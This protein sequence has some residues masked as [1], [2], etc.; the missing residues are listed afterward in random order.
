MALRKSVTLG[1]VTNG[2]ALL[3]TPTDLQRLQSLGAEMVRLEF[4]L[5]GHQQ[6]DSAI[7]AL[8]G[9]VLK[10]LSGAGIGVLGLVCNDAV[11]GPHNQQADWNKNATEQGGSDGTNSFQTAYAKACTT[12]AQS[13]DTVDEWEIFNEPNAWT[14]QPSS[15]VYSGGTFMYPSCYA[16]LLQKAHDALKAVNPGCVVV[17]GGLLALTQFGTDYGHSAAG[18]MDSLY[19]EGAWYDHEAP[20]DAIGYHYYGDGGKPFVPSHLMGY[21]L[22]LYATMGW[23]EAPTTYALRPLYITETGW[24]ADTTGAQQQ[25]D[26][27]SAIYA[28]LATIPTCAVCSWFSLHDSS[29]GQY[30]LYDSS[31]N[32]RPAAAAFSALAVG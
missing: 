31:D 16:Q 8:Y 6:W 22:D 29:A 12:L 27:L 26:N 18:Y 7:L 14:S 23:Y 15:G 3:F 1:Q 20:C 4:R 9:Q 30:G 24:K 21:I 17:T 32:T 11:P 25:A 28:T 2:T 10:M 13:F 19:Q 5:A